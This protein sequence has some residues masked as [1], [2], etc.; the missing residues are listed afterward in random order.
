MTAPARLR[1]SRD[2][3]NEADARLADV[4]RLERE[5]V[6][7]AVLDPGILR[8]PDVASVSSL[9]DLADMRC[10]TLLAELRELADRGVDVGHLPTLVAELRARGTLDRIG[11][12]LALSEMTSEIATS[13]R[14]PAQARKIRT[15]AA[16]REMQRLAR[17]IAA[18]D[19]S[20]SVLARLAA[21]AGE[22]DAIS[23]ARQGLADVALVGERLLALRT[24]RQPTSPMPGLLDP[25]PSLVIASGRPKSGKTSLALWLARAWVLG[26][27][28]WPGAPGL[29]GTRALLISREQ[30]ASRIDA[31]LRRLSVCAE[32][33][34][35]E[36]WT[37]RIAI[38]ARDPDLPAAARPLLTLDAPGIAQ[39]RGL[40]AAQRDADDPVGLVVL[41]SL[42]RL[43]PGAI[44]E[45]DN[46]AMS[47]WLDELAELASEMRTYVLAIHHVGHSTDPSRS[48]P[49]SAPRGASA[50]AAVAQ[51]VWLI[52][53]LPG[54]P[55]HRR[56]AV[57]GAAILPAELTLEV[58]PMTAEPGAV[59]YFRR[60]AAAGD[61][62]PHDLLVPGERISTRDLARRLAGD[63]LPDGAEPPGDL[64]RLASQL[65]ER[66]RAAGQVTVTPGKRGSLLITLTAETP[67]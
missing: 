16:E 8:D 7:A 12:E 25:E 46:S 27:A 31:T 36:A 56:L 4:V 63:A 41:D 11:G 38:V 17:V 55:Q 22:R 40:L 59:L 29:P 26:A 14:A 60:A 44:D 61:R 13:A 65:R 15:A 6:A 39:L 42:S 66:W 2:R 9:S 47:L 19:T 24:R 45:I 23:T 37:E 48:D 62:D 34:G 32:P 1:D 49:R 52:D 18:G 30:T 58:A 10:G 54:S 33:I 43:R 28:P 35:I 51:T 21:L 53:R 3:T 67:Q 20:S 50:I 57:D 64:Q 5:L